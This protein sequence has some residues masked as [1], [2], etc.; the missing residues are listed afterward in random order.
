VPSAEIGKVNKFLSIDS[1]NQGANISID[2]QKFVQKKQPEVFTSGLGNIAARQM[3][4]QNVLGGENNPN[5][6]GE[7]YGYD[8]DKFYSFL[9][10]MGNYPKNMELIS[11]ADA[12][13]QHFFTKWEECHYKIIAYDVAVS[14]VLLYLF[15]WTRPKAKVVE[16]ICLQG[17]DFEPGSYFS[18]YSSTII[19]EAGQQINEQLNKE[20]FPPITLRDLSVHVDQI[21]CEDIWGNILEPTFMPITSVFDLRYDTPLQLQ[22]KKNTNF[23]TLITTGMT[24]FQKLYCLNNRNIHAAVHIDFT[25]NELLGYIMDA[26]GKPTTNI[27][28]VRRNYFINTKW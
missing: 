15:P 27:S 16:S 19:P 1:P 9:H 11:I 10:L 18:I 7:P 5:P 21:Q 12:C 20:V 22:A 26:L 24:P 6:L 3:L 25:D 8:H 23:E 14:G 4:F 28:S 17:R 2:L 13:W